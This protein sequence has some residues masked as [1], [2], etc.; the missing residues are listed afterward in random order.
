MTVRNQAIDLLRKQKRRQKHAEKMALDHQCWFEPDQNHPVDEPLLRIALEALP[1]TQREIVVLKIWG[2]LSFK[3]ISHITGQSI[4]TA[5]S[6]Y[7]TALAQMKKK[8]EK[9]C[10]TNEN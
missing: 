4:S 2:Q 1:D 7:Q 5:H 8:L 6:R 9:S 3:E 10:R